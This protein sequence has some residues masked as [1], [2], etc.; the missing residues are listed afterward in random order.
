MPVSQVEAH[1]F[2]ALA[3]HDLQRCS[4]KTLQVVVE[5]R[6]SVPPLEDGGPNKGTWRPKGL[7]ASTGLTGST[8]PINLVAR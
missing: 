3:Q 5:I 6:V 2:T 8:I 4:R 7:Y 1:V